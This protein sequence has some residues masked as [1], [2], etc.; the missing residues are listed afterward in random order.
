MFFNRNKRGQMALNEVITYTL[1]ELSE[2]IAELQAV[3]DD[4]KADV[5][6]IL[7]TFE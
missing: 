2:R 1:I 6:D 3:V 7:D 4:V 5:E